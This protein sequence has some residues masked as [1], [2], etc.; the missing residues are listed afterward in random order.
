MSSDGQA[1]HLARRVRDLPSLS[2]VVVELL[3]AME[4]DDIDAQQLGAKIALDQ[5]LTA[6]TLRLANSSF[7]GM[8]SRVTSMQQAITVLGFHSIRGLVTACAVTGSFRPDQ[9]GGLDFTAF[10]RHSLA[11]A[12]GARLL[13]REYG[14]APESAF[15]AGLLHDIGVLVLATGQGEDYAGVL[16]W[17]RK[18]DCPR[19]DAERA[20][21]GIDHAQAG[22]ALAVHWKFPAAIAEAVAAHHAPPTDGAPS[23]ALVLHAASAFAHALDLSACEDE[24]VPPLSQQAWDLLALSERQTSALFRDT[25]ASFAELSQILLK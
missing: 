6:K 14:I 17:Q 19:I 7:Y 9:A 25:E 24:L 12:V 18:H 21:L 22:A 11:T 15:T 1:E 3:E 20:V 16:A 4:R 8:S 5:S 2:S 10:W 13:A 23:L